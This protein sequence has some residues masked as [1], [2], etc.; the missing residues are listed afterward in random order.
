MTN[1]RVGSGSFRAAEPKSKAARLQGLGHHQ[2]HA[3]L[4]VGLE[5][6]RRGQAVADLSVEA[7]DG[8]TNDKA[9]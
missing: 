9:F 5:A 2:R 8:N 1:T 4:A 7:G 3:V 6:H